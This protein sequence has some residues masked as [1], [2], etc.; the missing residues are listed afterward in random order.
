MILDALILI[1]VA[2]DL[3]WRRVWLRLLLVAVVAAVFARALS[4]GPAMRSALAAGPNGVGAASQYSGE[5]ARGVVSMF[6]TVRD[7]LQ[8]IYLPLTLLLWL[9]VSGPILEAF[10]R[11]KRDLA[12]GRS[13]GSLAP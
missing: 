7:N 11:R 4:I 9:A 8:R 3:R 13:S 10:E 2:C 6:E 1:L 12:A 5:Y